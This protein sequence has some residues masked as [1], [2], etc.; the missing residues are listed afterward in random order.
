MKAVL[1]QTAN[2]AGGADGPDYEHGWGLIDA[3]G[4]ADL[5]Q[6]DVTQPDRIQEQDRSDGETDEYLMTQAAPGPLRVSVAWTDPPGTPTAPALNP[7]TPMLVND[8]DVRVENV[9]TR[10]VYEPWVL[11]PD[12][13]SDPAA[14]GDNSVDNCEQ[15]YVANAS[16]GTYR[17]TVTHKGTLDSAQ[18]YS[19]AGSSELALQSPFTAAAAP[20]GRVEALGLANAPNPFNPRTTIRF[21]L[22]EPAAVTLGV[23]DV[24]GRLVNELVAG[25]TRSAGAHEVAWDGRDDA[26]RAVASGVYLCRLEAGGLIQV[27][28]MVLIR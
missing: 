13:P 2:E 22:G 10:T 6:A 8:L 4:A 3:W 23:Y 25:E 14:T 28:R 16:A 20:E 7:T 5:I 19:I 27:R 26:G 1:M 21:T 24:S 12:N 17:V 15:V 18:A 9:I 11:D